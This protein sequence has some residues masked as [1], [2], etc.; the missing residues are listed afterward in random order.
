MNRKK[1]ILFTILLFIMAFSWQMFFTY[2]LDFIWE[3][4]AA[5]Q[6]DKQAYPLN[7]NTEPKFISAIKT[8]QEFIK[9]FFK[10]E[11]L[12]K[13]SFLNSRTDRPYQYLTWDFLRIVFSDSAINYRIFKALT[14]A[15]IACIIF[16]IIKRISILLA[17]LGV[18]I[19][20]SSGEMW[21]AVAYICD[22]GLFAQLGV[23]LSVVLF[24]KLL[25]KKTLS[26]K[27][28]WLYY[29]LILLISNYAALAKGDG[30]YLALI[31]I[32][33][34]FIFRCKEVRFHLIPL[35]LLLIMQ[36]PILG[37]IKNIFTKQ[38]FSPID[39]ASRECNLPLLQALPLIIKNYIY[40]RN[41]LGLLLVVLLILVFLHLKTLLFHKKTVVSGI[42]ESV[43]LLNERLF[44]FMLWFISTFVMSALVRDFKYPGPYNWQLY[45]LSYFIAPFI[46]FLSYYIV[47][48]RNKITNQR[49]RLRFI[50]ICIILIIGQFFIGLFRVG[51]FR[52]TWG[53]YFCA[54]HNAEK[55]IDSTT[56]NALV[57]AL[58]EMS[59]LPFAFRKSNNV[60]EIPNPSRPVDYDWKY[61][62][63]KAITGKYK[64]I[65]VVT[66]RGLKFDESKRLKL[67][68]MKAV[69]GDSGDLFD[70]FRG[71]IL[72]FSP[73]VDVYHF[74]CNE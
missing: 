30:R 70:R 58:P 71:L 34:I 45:D 4:F 32:L 18:F 26:H 8:C 72:I 23:I 49:Y 36:I 3:D 2:G 47:F 29:F 9:L 24:L 59:Y 44:L 13:V 68:E 52:A 38:H 5:F 37:F 61:I 48:I 53:N 60:V 63:S 16:L 40:P 43:R 6:L 12:F 15:L 73:S 69:D 33:T 35:S 46:C 10:A 1:T 25:D 11:R 21:L 62:E 51:R 28:V 14:F 66:R 57:I 64:D 54:W 20:M 42:A 7:T 31:F 41:A 17:F 74:E 55:Y 39:I 65:F 67:K 22:P 19:Y 27:K 56:D 50:E